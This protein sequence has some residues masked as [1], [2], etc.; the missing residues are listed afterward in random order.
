MHDAITETAQK[1]HEVPAFIHKMLGYLK[2]WLHQHM[3]VG[4]YL[5][6]YIKEIKSM[7]KIK[8]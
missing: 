5:R 8:I 7:M 6:T 3:K 1:P 4:T 2:K